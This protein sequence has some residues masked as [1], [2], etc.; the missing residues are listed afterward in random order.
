MKNILA[1]GASNSK[2]S[3]NK[4]LASWAA[5]QVA[6]AEVHLIDLND[7]EM[8]M[9]G[10]DYETEHGHPENAIRLKTLIKETDGIIISF[11]EHNGSYTAVFKNTF[12]WLSRVEKG[13]WSQ[14]PIFCM[15]TSPGGR[16]GA[17]V[18]ALA[19]GNVPFSGGVLAGQFSLPSFQESFSEE[20][21]ITN[22]ELLEQFQD[23]LTVFE[24]HLGS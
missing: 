5:Q 3:I 12:D 11:A 6:D 19:A 8:P 14:K 21:G 2:N 1:F 4:K 16:G 17:T 23:Q 7:F 9:Y 15:A 22:K 24:K 20:E 13:T 10:I 18:L